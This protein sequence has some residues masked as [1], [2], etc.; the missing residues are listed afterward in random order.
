M[1]LAHQA[2][3]LFAQRFGGIIQNPFRVFPPSGLPP[4]WV[5]KESLDINR[6]IKQCVFDSPFVHW[7][8]TRILGTPVKRVSSIQRECS[9]DSGSLINQQVSILIGY[10]MGNKFHL[11]LNQLNFCWDEATLVIPYLNSNFNAINEEGVI[12]HII[13]EASKTISN[14][15]KCSQ[16][17]KM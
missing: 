3:F 7:V 2:L 8:K 9:M 5:P 12:F 10:N 13:N 6:R 14:G 16:V 1:G 11:S 15:F 4:S 17:P